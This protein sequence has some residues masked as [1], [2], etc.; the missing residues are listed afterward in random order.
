MHHMKNGDIVIGNQEEAE[1]PPLLLM[2][3]DLA[4]NRF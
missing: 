1:W 2:Q 4:A 3:R